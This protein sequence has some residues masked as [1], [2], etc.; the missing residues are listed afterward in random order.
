MSAVLEILD[1]QFEGEA[2]NAPGLVLVYFW[3]PWCGPCRLVAPSVQA[4][5]AHMGSALKVLK[6]E[7]DPNPTTV[8]RYHVE[9]VPA[10]VLLRDGQE[11]DRIEGAVT[12]QRIQE[13]IDRHC[14]PI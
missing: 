9:G 8:Q 4:I 13:L 2:L 10:L 14:I 6:M 5:A 12:K 11:I 1:P 7:V 3:A